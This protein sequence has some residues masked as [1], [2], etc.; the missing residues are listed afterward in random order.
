MKAKSRGERYLR[1]IAPNRTDSVRLRTLRLSLALFFHDLDA[2][3]D[4][5][6]TDVDAIRT[7]DEPSVPVRFLPVAE[8]ANRVPVGA[9]S[10]QIGHRSHRPRHGWDATK[11]QGLKPER[12]NVVIQSAPWL[13][14]LQLP[15]VTGSPSSPGRL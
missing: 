11:Y 9:R 13:D 5:L 10:R 1:P 6:F 3:F 15:A 2:Q 4:A 7:G 8:G 12:G 14:D